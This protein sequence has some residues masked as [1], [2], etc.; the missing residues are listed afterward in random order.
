MEK[1]LR[2]AYK[3]LTLMRA[4]LQQTKRD[5]QALA[6]QCTSLEAQLVQHKSRTA[7]DDEVVRLRETLA[8][9]HEELLAQAQSHEHWRRE[10]NAWKDAVAEVYGHP[11]S[12]IDLPEGLSDDEL[13]PAYDPPPRSL[14]LDDPIVL[15]KVALLSSF[16]NVKRLEYED[17]DAD[18][19]Q[20]QQQEALENAESQRLQLEIEA[21][22][23]ENTQLMGRVKVLSQT[24]ELLTHELHQNSN[25]EEEEDGSRDNQDQEDGHKP[26]K[27][28]EEEDPAQQEP[29]PSTEQPA[30]LWPHEREDCGSLLERCEVEKEGLLLQIRDAMSALKTQTA[31]DLEQLTLQ[32]QDRDTSF[33]AVEKELGRIDAQRLALV[34]ENEQ[35]NRSIA[36]YAQT[37]AILEQQ[38]RERSE[39]M[40]TLE[41]AKQLE[42]DQAMSVLQQQHK[43]VLSARE[44]A[45]QNELSAVIERA[46]EAKQELTMDQEHVQMLLETAEKEIAKLSERL[47]D[48]QIEQSRVRD[49]LE[50]AT[51]AMDVAQTQ[52]QAKQLQM[53]SLV[54]SFEHEKLALEVKLAQENSALA[55]FKTESEQVLD[56]LRVDHGH[57]LERMQMEQEYANAS[58][59]DQLQQELDRH[60]EEVLAAKQALHE[61]AMESAAADKVLLCEQIHQLTER[62]QELDSVYS[63][64]QHTVERLKTVALDTE[65]KNQRLEAHQDNLEQRNRG[66][67]QQLMALE[68]Q[69]RPQEELEYEAFNH[70]QAQLDTATSTSRSWRFVAR[71]LRA[72]APFL[73]ELQ[74]FA[75]HLDAVLSL[76]D[77]NHEA[78]RES[79][80]DRPLVEHVLS[81][82]QFASR[83]RALLLSTPH[84]A[85][86]KRLHEDLLQVLAQWHEGNAN[87]NPEEQEDV[88]PPPGFG[89][90]SP[91]MAL[92]LEQW[93]PD[94]AKQRMAKHWLLCMET[95]S[96]EAKPQKS[97]E[98]MEF[99]QTLQLQE[100]SLDV[101]EAFRMLV[102]P[103]LQR[104]PAIRVR[105]FSRHLSSKRIT[106]SVDAM[107]DK[108]WEMQ[109]HVQPAGQRTSPS[110]SP[111]QSKPRSQSV[112]SSVAT[113]PKASKLQIIQ[114]RLQLMQK[115]HS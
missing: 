33:A 37:H 57:Q 73:P 105:V 21:L 80:V 68:D 40:V 26:L 11:Y 35:L 104:N 93:T 31:N 49:Q 27:S 87:E 85:G 83:L 12:S 72:L 113:T 45:H 14:A 76:C 78:L 44:E 38:V 48:Q 47:S 4:D 52:L 75:T 17:E 67:E 16:S 34:E 112:T 106:S 65:S 60:W 110:T 41:R 89:I 74:S 98:P 19:E 79:R 6:L 91:E 62:I 71:K 108:N 54:Q 13:E 82:V 46:E 1:D 69:K 101:K 18:V 50:H 88:I 58:A 42:L 8:M 97:E 115:Q 15:E 32:V 102:V 95:W 64:A 63:Q 70:E 9:Q 94:E 28:D 114:E 100:L 84:L 5:K 25:N 7:S 36:A 92:I 55:K 111:S 39:E 90:A 51:H 23:Q 3:A 20:Q 10:L 56:L 77:A 107:D 30:G 61:K 22:K 109:I 24:N 29:E 2:D 53:D 103:I 59:R 43:A 86:V 99:S 96:A 66:L 81:Y